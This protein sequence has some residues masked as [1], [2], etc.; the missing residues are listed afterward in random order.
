MNPET[1]NILIVDDDALNRL[2]IHTN[3]EEQGF[4]VEDAE[5]GQQAMERLAAKTYDVVLLDLLMPVMDG[6][7]VLRRMKEDPA[8]RH[9]PV[10]VISATD[11]MESVVRCIEMGAMDHLPKPFD[12]LLLK[13]RLNASLAAK[14]LR[15]IELAYLEKIQVE[16]KKSEELLLNVLPEPIAEQLKQGKTTI[17]DHF[18]SVSVL[19]ADLVGF[20]QFVA[21]HTP[22]QM[23][24]L[25]NTVF[26]TFDR[27]AGQHGL[28][29]IK[30][31]GDAYMVAGG[32]PLPNPRHLEAAADMAI[33]IHREMEQLSS[34]G[35]IPRFQVR[36]GIHTG[37]VV[38]GVIGQRKFAYDLWGDTVNTASRLHTNGQGGKTLVTETVYELLK[39][40]YRMSEH[41][42]F[43]YKGLSAIRTYWL[44]GK[45]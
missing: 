30:T 38:A 39:D 27:L 35:A 21:S 29:K 20:T 43:K 2:L 7:E 22:D 14:R 19:F 37:P 25:L 40:R 5:D 9:I 33:D 24:T 15:D 42:T 12:P 17:I 3:L 11:E 45:V 16:Q 26:M 28:E 44:E 31:I 1:G 4:C 8:L 32:L 34:S 13:A 6:F 36:I 18:P 41:G 23:Y 10:I